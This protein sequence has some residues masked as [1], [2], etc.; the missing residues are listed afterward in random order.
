MTEK[1]EITVRVEAK[2]RH[3][4]NSKLEET[5][6]AV[7]D[8]LNG[9]RSNAFFRNIDVTDAELKEDSW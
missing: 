6:E 5:V 4:N 9:N 2:N 1:V 8:C 7:K 3:D